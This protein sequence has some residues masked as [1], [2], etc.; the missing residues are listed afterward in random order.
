[1][2]I[3]Q[4]SVQ[5]CAYR[6]LITARGCVCAG[7]RCV[8]VWCRRDNGEAHL[9]NASL[10]SVGGL[11]PPKPPLTRHLVS[12]SE[13]ARRCDAARTRANARRRQ[14]GRHGESQSYRS[15]THGVTR[16][17][18]IHAIWVVIPSPGQC[19][20][21][22]GAW[23]GTARIHSQ[24]MNWNQPPRCHVYCLGSSMVRHCSR[25]GATSTWGQHSAT[26]RGVPWS[27][28]WRRGCR[29]SRPLSRR[30]RC[31]R[32]RVKALWVCSEQMSQSACHRQTRTLPFAARVILR[33]QCNIN[34]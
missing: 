29:S 11:G 20:V 19:A 23:E 22:C 7:V 8:G 13:R 32:V 25:A 4:E 2:R 10:S 31:R 28:H 1:M 5:V 6:L 21:R 3:H 34:I 16:C 12:S 9:T 30:L 27:P 15:M 24:V 26:A 18:V 14:A 17:R 33:Y